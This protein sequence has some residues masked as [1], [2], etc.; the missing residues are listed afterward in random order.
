MC[1]MHKVL[2]R[3]L[4]ISLMFIC[5]AVIACNF[6]KEETYNKS[7]L[8]C[9]NC[10][11]GEGCKCASGEYRIFCRDGRCTPCVCKDCECEK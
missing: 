8:T 4:F 10:E 6:N 7:D 3:V 9:I 2:L 1:E 5:L 11:C